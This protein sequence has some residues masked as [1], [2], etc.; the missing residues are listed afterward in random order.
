MW[1]RGL[2]DFYAACGLSNTM[3][4]CLGSAFL[5]FSSSI[6]LLTGMNGAGLTPEF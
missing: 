4:G 1:S 5:A 3:L 6:W 2:L